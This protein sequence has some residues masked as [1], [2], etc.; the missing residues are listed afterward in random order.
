MT[1]T[2]IQLSDRQ[3]SRVIAAC[4][5]GATFMEANPEYKN[6]LETAAAIIKRAYM[7]PSER[8]AEVTP[9]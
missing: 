7:K 6:D 8:P 9:V 1:M 4:E 5:L 3:A 2:T